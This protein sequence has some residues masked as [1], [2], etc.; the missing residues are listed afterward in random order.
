M[1][2]NIFSF[3]A[4]SERLSGFLSKV[5]KI[6]WTSDI[7]LLD[8][9]SIWSILSS[10]SLS[11]ILTLHLLN[12]SCHVQCQST[13]P[14]IHCSQGCCSVFTLDLIILGYMMPRVSA[15]SG[16]LGDLVLTCSVA[17]LRNGAIH[18]INANSMTKASFSWTKTWRDSRD[19]G[20][21]WKPHD[22][23]ETI[24]RKLPWA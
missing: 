14:H 10:L 7:F 2:L 18:W 11:L 15:A 6:S 22:V 20:C 8:S 4:T 23:M 9:W 19:R 21:L 5:L 17:S 16:I 12:V 3:S 1:H 13:L 24:H